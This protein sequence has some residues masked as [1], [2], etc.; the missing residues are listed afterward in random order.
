MGTAFVYPTLIAAISDAVLPVDRPP[1]VGIYRFWRDMGY[2]AGALIAGLA[3][4]TI[5][6]PGAIALVAALTAASNLGP[7]RHAD[8]Y[9]TRSAQAAG[10]GPIAQSFFGLA[11]RLP[12]DRPAVRN[13]PN[14]SERGIDLQTA[15]PPLPGLPDHRDQAVVS[16]DDPLRL[17]AKLIEALQPAAQEPLEALT[18]LVAAAS[19]L[20]AGSCHSMSGSNS[21]STTDRCR[22]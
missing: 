9:T 1:A 3:A 16:L 19:G 18:P 20:G 8:C 11:S 6:Y 4:D 10:L 12:T 7:G 2:V 14:M 13:G 17:D 5:A 15:R 21:S 22:G